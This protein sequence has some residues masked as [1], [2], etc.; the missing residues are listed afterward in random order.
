MENKKL[1][2]KSL[3]SQISKK[4]AFVIRLTL[5]HGNKS[6]LIAKKFNISPSAVC[7]LRQRAFRQLGK[8]LVNEVFENATLGKIE[9]FKNQNGR[10]HGKK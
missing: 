8:R 3:L 5:K 1:I 2:L 9:E 4:Q 10:Q 6:S 7:Q